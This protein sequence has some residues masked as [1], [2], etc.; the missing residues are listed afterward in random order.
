MWFRAAPLVLL[1]V[2]AGP[3]TAASLTIEVGNVRN[4]HGHIHV[5]VCPK[6]RFLKDDCPYSAD[7]PARSGT[8]PITVQN[9]PP[10]Q[11]AIQAFHDE[12]DNHRVDR[13]LF[14][15]PKE[16]VGFSND[17]P[18]RLGPPKWDDAVVTISG[19]V[20]LRLRMRYFLGF[21]GP[22]AAQK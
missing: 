2:M 1:V 5:D 11:Y 21:S 3:V 18:I 9:V 6:D 17:A 22:D 13:A 16:G 15:I 14:G 7:T 12:N 4:A 20:R 10:G 8:T 19:D